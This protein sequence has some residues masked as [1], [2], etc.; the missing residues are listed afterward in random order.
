MFTTLCFGHPTS[1]FAPAQNLLGSVQR[2]GLSWYVL[3]VPAASLQQRTFRKHALPL[4]HNKYK[5][6]GNNH[7]IQ[8]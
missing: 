5:R 4:T 6:I 1:L 2:R 3:A 7:F 8:R